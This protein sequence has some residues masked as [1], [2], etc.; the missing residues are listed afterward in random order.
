M[1]SILDHTFIAID[2][3]TT[4]KYPLE[5][6][7]CEIAAVKFV[8]GKVTEVFSSLVKPTQKMSEEVIKIH[9]ITN[10]MVADAPPMAAVI[11]Q[12]RKFIGEEILVAHHAPFDLGFIAVEFEKAGLAF[13]KTPNICSS[14]L[15]RVVITDSINHKLQTLIPHLGLTKG[16]AHR[17]TD[18]AQACGELL[19][20]CYERGSIA[21]LD[22]VWRLQSAKL[23]WTDYSINALR[24][25]DQSLNILVACIEQ[26][27][28]AILKYGTAAS[29]ERTIQPIGLVRGP[30]GDFL[31]ATDDEGFPKRFY[32][33]KVVEVKRA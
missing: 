11:T 10:E 7:I 27:S 30:D 2:T 22:D 17:A 32:L 14:R 6:E 18:D 4:G 9:G 20:K 16:A 3:E 1:P 31:I 5:S 33:T 12:F 8:S 25:K 24:D 21:S 29:S 13:P 15:A 23:F 28:P 19:L 26:K